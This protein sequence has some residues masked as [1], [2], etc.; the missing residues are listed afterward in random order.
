MLAG[1]H[2]CLR[3]SSLLISHTAPMQMLAPNQD[4][5]AKQIN[6]SYEGGSD[7]DTI[8]VACL[9]LLIPHILLQNITCRNTS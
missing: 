6:E 1:G 9:L 4:H 8:I 3:S 5:R 7:K 2:K